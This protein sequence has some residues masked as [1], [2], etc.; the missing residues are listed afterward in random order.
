MQVV[1]VSAAYGAGG[2]VIGPAVA[3]RLG[4]PFVDRAIPTTVAAEIGVPLE[5]ALA[6]D[7]RTEHG[8]G[9]LLAGAARLPNVTLGGMD[10]YLPQQS[11]VPEEEFVA[12]TENVIRDTVRRGG[13]VVLGRAGALVLAGH[14]QTLHVR[15]DGPK[16]RR[17]AQAMRLRG[18]DEG[19]AR[20]EQQDTDRA[21]M[22][23]V[24]HFYRVDPT[25]PGLYHFILDSTSLSLET[26]VDLI[27][28]A[29]GAHSA[30]AG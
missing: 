7:D 9:R 8:I 15:L 4:V 6:H 29:A 17:M 22:A 25:A 27:V 10:A 12:R 2:S 26:C 28:S 23:Y 14:P 21:R 1:T 11:L 18:L 13:G 30:T 5:E 19:V 3:E 24:K 16:D 20:R